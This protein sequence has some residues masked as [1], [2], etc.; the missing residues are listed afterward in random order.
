MED[1]RFAGPLKAFIPF[2]QELLDQVGG[3][4]GQL[5]LHFYDEPTGRW[6]AIATTVIRDGL[7][8][9]VAHLTLFSLMAP[10]QAVETFVEPPGL[11]LGA[12]LFLSSL[13]DE[14]VPL[15]SGDTVSATLLVNPGGLRIVQ[16]VATIIYPEDLIQVVDVDISRSVCDVWESEPLIEPGRIELKCSIS[17]RGFSGGSVRV[18][19][20]AVRGIGQGIA[21]LSI[22]S[23]AQVN[24]VED[25]FNLLGYRAGVALYID[26]EIPVPE[27]PEP[28]VPGTVRRGVPGLTAVIAMASWLAAGA[29]ASV[30]AVLLLRRLRTRRAI[31]ALQRHEEEQPPH[32]L[33]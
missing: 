9:R 14:S 25:F 17:S 21:D 15:Q 18:V 8:A 20:I 12:S 1:Y 13:Y 24:A 5:T 31:A 27:F 33:T 10:R 30:L 7:Y 2:S 6:A 11:P 29:V 16:V 4:P 3:D 19:D 26:Q 32:L 23:D 28:V 22:G